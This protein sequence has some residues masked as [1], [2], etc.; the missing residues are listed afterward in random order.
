MPGQSLAAVKSKNR[1]GSGSLSVARMVLRPGVSAERCATCPSA[2]ARVTRWHSVEFVSDR[3]VSSVAFSTTRQ[4][5]GEPAQ[6]DVRADPVLAVVEHRPQPER[7]LHVAPAAFDLQRLLVRRRQ[8]VRGQ[9][10]VG[11]SAAA[12]CR[13]DDARA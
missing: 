7:A 2:V 8:V 9:G 3:Q 4:Q 6:L 12:T 1:G 5:L 11:G 10:G 13:P